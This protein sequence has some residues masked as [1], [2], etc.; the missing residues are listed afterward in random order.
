MV[1]KIMSSWYLNRIVF[2]FLL[3]G[4]VFNLLTHKDVVF[5]PE[6]SDFL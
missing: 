4:A 5:S 6:L 2:F 3:L 1:G